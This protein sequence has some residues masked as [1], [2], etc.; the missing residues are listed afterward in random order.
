[1]SDGWN[2][3]GPGA[4]RVAAPVRP[5]L[6]LDAPALWAGPV[7]VRADGGARRPLPVARACP[8]A[9][10]VVPPAAAVA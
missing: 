9:W 6:M 1:V 2:P 8:R 7:A 5:A 3:A 10:G 4:G